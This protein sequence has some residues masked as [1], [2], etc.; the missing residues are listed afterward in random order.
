MT[1]LNGKGTLYTYTAIHQPLT[2]EEKLPF[3][4][5]VIELDVSGTLCKN[6]VRLMSNVVDAEES[7]FEIARN[8]I[9]NCLK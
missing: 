1:E 5:V 9:I 2:Y 6:T 7:E 3:F 4:I 8:K